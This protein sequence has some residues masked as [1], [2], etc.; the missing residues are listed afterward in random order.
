[1]E[2]RLEGGKTLQK[3]AEGVQKQEGGKSWEINQRRLKSLG[4]GK[5]KFARLGRDQL[6]RANLSGAKELGP[7]DGNPPTPSSL[8]VFPRQRTPFQCVET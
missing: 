1:M 4:G 3:R 8:P 5:K 7:R 6:L 2:W